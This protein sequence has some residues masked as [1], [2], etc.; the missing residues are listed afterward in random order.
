MRSSLS[1]VD[2][3]NVIAWIGGT[4]PRSGIHYGT[5]PRHVL[6]VYP[7]ASDGPSPV[8]VFFYGGGWEEGERGDYRFVGSALAGRGLTTVIPDYRVF[9]EVRFPGFVEDA[10]AAI[11]WTVDHVAELGGDPRRITVMGH[12]AGAHIAALLAFDRQW[13]ARV[14]L[15]AGQDVCAL[16]G[17]AG[18]YDFLP[19]HSRKLKQIFGPDEGLAATQPINFVEAG[20][21]PAFLA[22]GKKDWT[23]DPG[24]TVRLTERMRRLGSEAEMKLYDRVDHRT[25]IGAFARPLQFLAPV[26]DDVAGFAL[27]HAAPRTLPG[28]PAAR[29]GPA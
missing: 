24:N 1:P 8:I 12:S 11:R 6:D 16:I 23:V 17:L 13:L 19:L 5:H 21:P 15:D 3:L 18:P 22:T 4:R 26:L 2:F 29:G 10:A 7:A 9:P 25:L 28:R 27:K 20:A 14:G